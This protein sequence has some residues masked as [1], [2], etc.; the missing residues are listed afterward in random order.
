MQQQACWSWQALFTPPSYGCWFTHVDVLLV[1]VAFVVVV[2]RAA[3]CT[4]GQCGAPALVGFSGKRQYLE[5]MNVR[6]ARK[7]QTVDVGPQA[8][9]P[10]GWPFPCTTEVWVLSSTSG[11]SALT[12]EQREGPYERLAARLRQ[13]PW[14]HALQPTC[15]QRP[16]AQGLVARQ[17][18]AAA[19]AQG[20]AV[21]SGEG[22]GDGG[23]RTEGL[24]A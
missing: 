8:D 24:D 18:Q 13:L 6:R 16:E 3:G 1:V 15:C 7:V 17:G 22:P 10:P 2:V 11:A 20:L 19:G 23:V 9:L 21:A 5:L 12:Q 4:C 14:P